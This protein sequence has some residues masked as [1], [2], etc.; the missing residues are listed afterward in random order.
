MDEYIASPLVNDSN[1]YI[2]VAYKN[3]F[4]DNNNFKIETK[5]VQVGRTVG[6]FF[7]LNQY[8]Q[9]QYDQYKNQRSEVVETDHKRESQVGGPES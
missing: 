8:D 2:A 4:H 1:R 6:T 3:N 7:S 9:Y 5:K